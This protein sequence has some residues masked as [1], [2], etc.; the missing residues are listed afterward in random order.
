MGD[1]G[2]LRDYQME[3]C[4]DEGVDVQ[5]SGSGALDASAIKFIVREAWLLYFVSV[6][7]ILGHL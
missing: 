3:L 2:E 4:I 5:E 6:V 7:Y 1:F